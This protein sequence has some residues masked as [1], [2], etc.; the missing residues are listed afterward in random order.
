MAIFWR[1]TRQKAQHGISTLIKFVLYVFL[2]YVL[3]EVDVWSF[4]QWPQYWAPCGWCSLVRSN[5]LCGERNKKNNNMKGNTHIKIKS[6]S[7]PFFLF[8]PIEFLHHHAT[9]NGIL[10]VRTEQHLGY[11]KMHQ[12]KFNFCQSNVI[13]MDDVWN[14]W[15]TNGSNWSIASRESGRG[16]IASVGLFIHSK[17]PKTKL[18]YT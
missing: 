11:I 8:K 1:L 16:H 15:K 2:Q 9:G 13:E 7:P 17:Q 5:N 10:P 6:I 14:G 18:T 12:R 4:R 3:L